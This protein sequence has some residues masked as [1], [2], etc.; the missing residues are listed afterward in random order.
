MKCKYCGK[1]LRSVKTDMSRVERELKDF[2][3]MI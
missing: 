2:L 1:E 3:K